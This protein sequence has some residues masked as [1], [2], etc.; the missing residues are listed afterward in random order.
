MI[1]HTFDKFWFLILGSI[2]L[3]LLVSVLITFVI[4]NSKTQPSDI[5]LAL[6]IFDFISIASLLIQAGNL[7][8]L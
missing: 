3:I 8:K 2:N 6:T 5:I 4:K 7:N 1:L